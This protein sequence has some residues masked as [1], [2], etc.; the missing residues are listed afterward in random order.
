MR[1]LNARS[2]KPLEGGAS[3]GLCNR[4]YR[5][6]W[7]L[8]WL[9][10]ASWTPPPFHVWRVFLLRMFGAKVDWSARVYSSVKI[11]FP[12][13]LVMGPHAVMGP[14][15]ICYCQ[16]PI[17]IGEKAVISQGAHLCAGSHDIYDS[18]FQLITSP[19]KICRMAWVAAEAFIGPGVTIGEEA[20]I[21]ARAVLFK[22]AEPRG[23]YVGNPAHLIKHR[24]FLR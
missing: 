20:V 4:I 5:S 13:Y 7:I 2:S 12:P 14:R 22:D 8:A 16:A 15:V 1:I 21:G 11:W 24:T 10:F 23:V 6:V 18:S 19:I 9:I 3:F 17:S